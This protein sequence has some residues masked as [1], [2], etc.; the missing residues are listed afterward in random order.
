MSLWCSKELITDIVQEA[1]LSTSN[2]GPRSSYIGCFLTRFRFIIERRFR[3][4]L[5]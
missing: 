5:E 4:C 3:K 1:E 2:F